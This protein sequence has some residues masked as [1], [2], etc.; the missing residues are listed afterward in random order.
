MRTIKAGDYVRPVS[1]DTAHPDVGVVVSVSGRSVIVDWREAEAR[2]PEFAEE[3]QVCDSEGRAL[4][5]GD[6]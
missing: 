3:L 5:S 1:R 4:A 6:K 2:Y